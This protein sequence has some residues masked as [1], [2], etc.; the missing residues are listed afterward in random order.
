[1][2]AQQANGTVIRFLLLAVFAVAEFAM[3]RGGDAQA[4]TVLQMSDQP[5]P[6]M[7][8]APP[9]IPYADL[10]DLATN[11]PTVLRAKIREARRLKPEQVGN[12]AP[13][14][15]RIYVVARLESLVSGPAMMGDSIRF[16]VDVPLDAR[17]R[18]P[19][20]KKQQVLVFARVVQAAG[21]TADPRRAADLQLIAPDAMVAATP[22]N[23]LRV[24]SILRES[25][26]DGAPPPIT[27]VR[28]AMFVP[29]NLAGEGET[30]IFL[31]ARDAAPASITVLRRP[32]QQ[33][34]WGVSTSEIVDQAARPPLRDTLLW[35]RL[36]CF[37]PA[38]LPSAS[39]VSGSPDA[40]AQAR[41]DYALV[42]AALGTC[43]RNRRYRAAR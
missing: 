13:D 21:R 41:Q 16:L 37:L 20:L 27:G 7:A 12:L 8:A 11:A 5:T 36:A 1:M 4:R 42:M 23:E 39:L 34:V 14:V 40:D 18:V 28:E 17:G 15:A 3:I 2:I 10:A 43:Q 22:E 19:K 25:L 35:Y 9:S 6:V 32:G 30:Q 31:S 24:R 26:A 38:A 33:P 29:G